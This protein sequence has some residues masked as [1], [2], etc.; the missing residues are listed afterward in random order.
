[1]NFSKP[2]LTVSTLAIAGLIAG[3]GASSASSSTASTTTVSPT[4]TADAATTIATESND[5][6]DLTAGFQQ[7]LW[8]TN[9]TVTYEGGMLHYVSDGVPNHQRDDQYA[10]PTGGVVVPDASSATATD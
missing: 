9:V 5:T 8:G 7:A 10:V 4:T 2:V 3:C 1:M 6:G